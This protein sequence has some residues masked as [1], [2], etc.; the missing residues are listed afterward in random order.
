MKKMNR[1][2]AIVFLTN[3]WVYAS[4]QIKPEIDWAD[5][6]AGTFTMGSPLDESSRREDEAQYQVTLSSF[7]ISKNEITVLQFKQF[8]DATGYVTDAESKDGYDGGVVWSG[9][10]VA[11]AGVNWRC[12]TRGYP[13]DSRDYNH[14]V[15]YISWWDARAFAEWMNCRLPTEAEWEYVCRAGTTTPFSTGNSWTSYKENSTVSMS[16]NTDTGAKYVGFTKPAGTLPPNQWGVNDMHGNVSEWCSDWYGSY[17]STPQTDPTG[18]VTGEYRVYRGGA[19]L[20]PEE[21]CRSAVRS[22][23]D[24]TQLRTNWIGFRIVSAR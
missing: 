7:K 12:D 2:L 23:D 9:K 17:P 21:A 16:F 14:P 20:S 15:L 6:P 8:V 1:L 24:P 19:W 10:Y 13:R 22:Y 11:V 18:P 4:A 3:V 5:I